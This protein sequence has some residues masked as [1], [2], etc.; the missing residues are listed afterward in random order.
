MRRPACAIVSTVLALVL[1]HSLVAAPKIPLVIVTRPTIVAFFSPVTP[2]ELKIDPDTNEALADFQF[3][4]KKMRKPLHDAGIDFTE[5]YAKSFQV[6]RG[7]QIT[8]FRPAKIDVGYY[9]V[10]PGKEP[11]VEYGVLT[12]TD[13]LQI[14]NEYFGL[15]PK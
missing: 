7:K 13:L 2:D 1:S 9:L 8:I 15:A 10:T 11:R 14:A 6:Q 5:V 12:D 3:Y 4:A